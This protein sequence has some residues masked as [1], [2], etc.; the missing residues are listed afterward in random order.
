MEDKRLSNAISEASGGAGFVSYGDV[1]N[2][3][4]YNNNVVFSESSY[5]PT[6]SAVQGAKGIEQ[7][8]VIRG[9]RGLK[10]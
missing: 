6:W 10:L 9:Q 2:E 3:N 1:A 4:D 7:W 8:V 5:K